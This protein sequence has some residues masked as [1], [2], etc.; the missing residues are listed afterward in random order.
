MNNR[1]DL[2]KSWSL[3]YLRINDRDRPKMNSEW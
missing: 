3:S 1:L 2:Q